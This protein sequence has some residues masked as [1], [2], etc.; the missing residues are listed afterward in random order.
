LLECSRHPE[1]AIATPNP[2]TDTRNCCLIIKQDGD[3]W[4][5]LSAHLDTK[6]LGL[7]SPFFSALVSFSHEADT[8]APVS[9]RCVHASVKHHAPPHCLRTWSRSGLMVACAQLDVCT[10]RLAA[11]GHQERPDLNFAIVRTIRM[12]FIDVSLLSLAI[13]KPAPTTRYILAA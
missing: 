2:I 11:S 13:Y 1:L 4:Y 7:V 3:A 12:R 8:R 10:F 9:V 6:V 5:R